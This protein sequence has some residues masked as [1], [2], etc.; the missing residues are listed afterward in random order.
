MLKKNY[1]GITDK[2][3]LVVNESLNSKKR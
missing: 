3:S 1:D 2:S